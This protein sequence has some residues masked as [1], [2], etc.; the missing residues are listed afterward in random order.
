MK[1]QYITDLGYEIISIK[2]DD[3]EILD[4]TKKNDML[5]DI[6]KKLYKSPNTM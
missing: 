2:L 6:A 3:W 1:Y 4:I 5:L